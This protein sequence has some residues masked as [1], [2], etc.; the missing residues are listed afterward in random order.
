MSRSS[1]RFGL[2]LMVA[3]LLQCGEVFAQ[4]H[5]ERRFIRSGNKGYER[6]DY[7]AAEERYRTALEREPNSYEA[8]FNLSDAL[9]RQQ[10][11][12]EAAQ[13]LGKLSE[14][15]DLTAAQ[16][17]K[18]MHNLGNVRL[19][20]QQLQ[21][22]ADCYKESLRARP[23]DLETKY[24]LAYVQQLLK[25]QQQNQDQNQQNQNQDQ[26]QNRNQQGQ[27]GQNDQNPNGQNDQNPNGQNQND[28]D[29]QNNQNGQNPNDRQQGR[30]DRNPEQ[31]GQQDSD[32]NGQGD[33][34]RDDRQNPDRQPGDGDRNSGDRDRQ[35]SGNGG[36]QISREDAENILDALQQQEDKTREKVNAQRA[37]SVGASGKNW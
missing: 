26:N 18:V 37:V 17:A 2:L 25:D 3:V 31:N 30:N 36:G 24:N 22:A 15:G 23:D 29:N 7:T 16:R 34:N 11:Y 28:R 20:Q 32:D 9:Y 4:A 8:A 19:A 6:Q 1:V 5:P 13:M 12:D 35:P 10:K 21:E 33:Q 27:N 14:R